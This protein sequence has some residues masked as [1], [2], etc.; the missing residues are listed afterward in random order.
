[1]YF[2]VVYNIDVDVEVWRRQILAKKY[3][4]PEVD[5]W[6]LGVVLY[7][8]VCGRYPFSNVA[9][10]ITGHYDPLDAGLTPGTNESQRR[11]AFFQLVH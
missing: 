11:F 8:M 10:I 4:G 9:N 1:M 7:S 3:M 6:S 5:V 2:V